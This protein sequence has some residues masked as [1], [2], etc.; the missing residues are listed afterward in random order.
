MIHKGRIK[1]CIESTIWFPHVL[2]V[3]WL[4][5]ILSANVLLLLTSTASIVQCGVTLWTRPSSADF[6]TS[7]KAL[8]KQTNT[9]GRTYWPLLAHIQGRIRHIFHRR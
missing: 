8:H 2:L 3:R 7:L 5:E 4:G 6:G 9:N 1:V